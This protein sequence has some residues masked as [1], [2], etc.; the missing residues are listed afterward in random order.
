MPVKDEGKGQTYCRMEGVN[1]AVISHGNSSPMLKPAKH[2]QNFVAL[3]IEN[4]IIFGVGLPIPFGRDAGSY[5]STEQ[6][7]AKPRC[8]IASICKQFLSCWHGNQ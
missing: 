6:F 1:T 5:A 2:N 3:F 4:F 8:I 7:L